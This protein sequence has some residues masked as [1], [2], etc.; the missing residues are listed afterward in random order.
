[1]AQKHII[2]IDDD[3]IIQKI[4]KDMLEKNDFTVEGYT[5]PVEGIAAAKANQPDAILLDRIMPEMHGDEVI[6]AL[7]EDPVTSNI[8]IIMLTSSNDIVDV[9]ASLGLGARDYIVKPF[10]QDNLTIRLKKILGLF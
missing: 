10:D 1:M 8:P 6:Q 2:A 4:I 9:T 3:K 7:Q 5:N